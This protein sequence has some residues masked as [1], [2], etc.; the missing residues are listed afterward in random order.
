MK[1]CFSKRI[2]K[3]P[4]S[5]IREILKVT[6][7][8]EV[9]SF[10]GGL[11]N[12]S[13]IDTEGILE[14]AETV[15]KEDGR[16]ALQYSN[17]E[18][19]LPL[20]EYIAERYRKR[21]GLLISSDEI[22]ITNGSQQCLDLLGKILIDKDD[23]VLIE[24]PGYLG[25]IQAFSLYEPEFFSVGLF[26][27]GPDTNELQ[28]I[29]SEE[30]PKIFYGIPNSQNPSGIT[31]SREKREEIGEILS[32][33]DTLFIEDDAYGELNFTDEI[34]EP[35]KKY[36]PDL[37][38]MTGSFSKIISPGMRLGWICAPTEII[39]KISTAK[40]ASDLHSNY[41]SQ[42]IITQYLQTND[43][44]IHIQKI[45]SEYSNRCSFMTRLM[46]EMF[47]AEIGHTS[48]KGGMFIWLTL[49]QN[50]SSQKLFE[51]AMEKNVAILPGYP[52]YV[53]GGGD[54][55]VRINFSNSDEDDIRKGIEVLSDIFADTDK[56]K[57]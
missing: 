13:L 4:K 6:Q 38:V 16:N 1:Y 25:A 42:R 26:E 40:Q 32:D 41:L 56:I 19:Y 55:T 37:G 34:F 54:N 14:A 11:P 5:F 28:N 20:R 53:N 57:K 3:T 27:D 35:V 33:T 36:L 43:I 12:P 10:A 30:N 8:P 47:P 9:I 51:K 22:L 39:D 49:P 24:R 15:I 2:Q 45:R 18:G 44:D 31:Y 29:V 50:I 7:Q 17:T 52:F 23:A 21:Y 48:P 46:D